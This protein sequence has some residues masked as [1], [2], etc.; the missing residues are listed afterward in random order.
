[1]SLH[2]AKKKMHIALYM[3]YICIFGKQWWKAIILIAK[4]RQII[5]RAGHFYTKQKFLH[6]PSVQINCAAAE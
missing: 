1:M 4:L 5:D 2:S 6:Q 3:I